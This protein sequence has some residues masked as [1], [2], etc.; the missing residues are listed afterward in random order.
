MPRRDLGEGPP[1]PFEFRIG[2]SPERLGENR[3]DLWVL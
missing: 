3:L 2:K 1:T